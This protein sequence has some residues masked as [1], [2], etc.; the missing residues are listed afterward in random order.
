M[1][2]LLGLDCSRLES[3]DARN[4]NMIEG[5]NSYPNYS[6]GDNLQYAYSHRWQLTARHR[7]ASNSGNAHLGQLL[8][9][10]YYSDLL[11]S[12]F[13]HSL[14]SPSSKIIIHSNPHL[15]ACGQTWIAS[16]SLPP[17]I[18]VAVDQ[19]QVGCRSRK[20]E[21]AHRERDMAVLKGYISVKDN[22]DPGKVPCWLCEEV[23]QNKLWMKLKN[24]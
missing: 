17:R 3:V 6:A 10:H 8:M 2:K 20:V 19:L 15:G 18:F 12:A 24:G 16:G 22:V 5:D 4:G 7:T 1:R 14:A 21:S 23:C 11:P 13:P 9:P